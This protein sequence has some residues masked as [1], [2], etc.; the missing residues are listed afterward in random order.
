MAVIIT[1]EER[2]TVEA[3]FS[4][5]AHFNKKKGVSIIQDQHAYAA[6]TERLEFVKCFYPLPKFLKQRPA[7][8]AQVCVNEK[9]EKHV[10]EE[11]VSSSNIREADLDGKEDEPE[12]ETEETPLPTSTQ[13][14][15]T[16]AEVERAAESPSP[17]E[18]TNVN[19]D[20]EI[21]QDFSLLKVISEGLRQ[22][23]PSDTAC[24]D[25]ET[26]SAEGRVS[27]EIKDSKA[28]EDKSRKSEKSTRR[29]K[30]KTK[31]EKTYNNDE[32]IDDHLEADEKS[33]KRGSSIDEGIVTS[34]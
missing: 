8:P 19:S 2:L 20:Q 32:D 11:M 12:T 23:V 33:R 13:N 10:K 6:L 22:K 18:D 15:E 34:I 24:S 7:S 3:V 5:V 26:C 14:P 9:K 31:G 27:N 21:F 25:S 28:E 4:Q 16:E 30:A 29:K 17:S 1:D